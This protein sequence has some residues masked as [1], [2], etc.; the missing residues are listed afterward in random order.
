MAFLSKKRPH[1]LPE[2]LKVRVVHL[3]PK[4]PVE[5]GK[6]PKIEKPEGTQVQPQ[7]KTLAISEIKGMTPG[8]VWKNLPLK[9]K[10]LTIVIISIVTP[11]IVFPMY[12]IATSSFPFFG[13]SPSTLRIFSGKLYLT[14]TT[15]NDNPNWGGKYHYKEVQQTTSTMP[16]KIKLQSAS[17]DGKV[18]FMGQTS[19]KLSYEA[20]WSL[21]ITSNDPDWRAYVNPSSGHISGWAMVWQQV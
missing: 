3:P 17:V 14:T 16:F 13:P 21:S 1:K 6:P 11:A 4:G 10:I 19:G 18:I 8:K 7:A 5:F 20:D 2:K 15:I 9:Q 12:W